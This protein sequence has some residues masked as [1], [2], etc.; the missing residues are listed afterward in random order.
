MNSLEVFSMRKIICLEKLLQV[1]RAR[2]R[3]FR[4]ILLRLLPDN[5]LCL[6]EEECF[7][8]METILVYYLG[9]KY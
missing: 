4:K 8:E 1:G 2:Y 9:R 3:T 6:F 7:K 5:T